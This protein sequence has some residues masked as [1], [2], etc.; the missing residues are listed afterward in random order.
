MRVTVH[1]ILVCPADGCAPNVFS[2]GGMAAWL[3]LSS[4]VNPPFTRCDFKTFQTAPVTS[5]RHRTMGRRRGVKGRAGRA[6]FLCRHEYGKK[7]TQF[8]L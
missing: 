6:R 8:I 4:S 1:Q 5:A 2:R 3:L 7:V